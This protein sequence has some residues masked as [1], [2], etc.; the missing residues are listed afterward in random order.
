[1]QQAFLVT[2]L[3]ACLLI[4]PLSTANEL[5]SALSPGAV[6][7]VANP[8]RVSLLL[9]EH[10][11]G[12]VVSSPLD[13]AYQ[14]LSETSPPRLVV[15]ISVASPRESPQHIPASDILLKGL[16]L[17]PLPG[18]GTRLVLDLAYPIP[19][20]EELGWELQLDGSYQLTIRVNR[21]FVQQQ[22]VLVA[23]GVKF[24]VQRRG[25][26]FGP[27]MVNFLTVAPREPLLNL[28]IGLGRGG[29]QGLETVSAIVRRLGALA[30][31]N[32][33]FF[34]TNGLPLGL[35]VDKGVLISPPV[36]D[37]TAFLILDDGSAGMD[38]A[39]LRTRVMLP[40]GMLLVQG[41][42][43][44]RKN[45]EVVIYNEAFGPV[46]PRSPAVCELV[47]R[48]GVVVK[49]AQGG[50]PLLPGTV[51]VAGEP[52]NRLKLVRAGQPV[53]VVWELSLLGN[54]VTLPGSR[55][56]F[57]LGA[58][59]RLLANGQLQV[60]A[61]EERFRPDVAMGRAPRTALGVTADGGLLLVTVDGRQ[62]NL[63][64][65][66]TLE[67]LARLMLELGAK[68][69]M[70]LDGGG[71]T[72]MVVQGRVVNT[73]SAGTERAVGNALLVILEDPEWQ[74]PE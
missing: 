2:C 14:V 74:D 9:E 47:V 3:A 5:S 22:E 33:T 20:W 42:N 55:V 65:G 28:R 31:V 67:E 7:P 4:S 52:T 6:E 70:N 12:L 64:V 66:M 26:L 72:T 10:H 51:V 59:P 17:L 45:D 50:T 68:E 56:H 71:S 18:Q 73:P 43:R 11:V 40:D 37:R 39:A 36:Y 25:E 58:G 30:G 8:V 57:A 60:T 46:T 23:Q 48:D 32:G 53:D 21:R 35:L 62:G 24:G 13:H 63:A 29:T 27:V 1:M 61:E 15:D 69:A 49:V 16:R 38:R 54:Q 44:Q 34:H 19:S 41:V